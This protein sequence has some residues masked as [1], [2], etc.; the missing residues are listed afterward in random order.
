[1]EELNKLTDG[2]LTCVEKKLLKKIRLMIK[3]RLQSELLL[4][5]ILLEAHISISKI[6]QGG[7][8]KVPHVII[9]HIEGA[10][11]QKP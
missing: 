9:E 11:E 2:K 1:M 3:N 4:L 8:K 7:C 10:R 6:Y 5:F